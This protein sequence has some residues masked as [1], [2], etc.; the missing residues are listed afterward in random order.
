[1]RRP[2]FIGKRDFRPRQG[3]PGGTGLST[4]SWGDR[5][6]IGGAS[7]GQALSVVS[8]DAQGEMHLLYS[9]SSDVS[10]PQA[11]LK[12]F[13]ERTPVFNTVVLERGL[14]AFAVED[15]EVA[16][17]SFSALATL[18]KV[19]VMGIWNIATNIFY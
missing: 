5:R 6:S 1:M 3:C 2:R 13:V 8:P 11:P 15:T 14:R 9:V 4:G 19:V 17:H 18:S 12:Q 7:K 16:E 10:L